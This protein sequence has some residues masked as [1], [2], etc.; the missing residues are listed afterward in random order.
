MLFVGIIP[1]TRRYFYQRICIS[2]LCGFTGLGQLPGLAR[3]LAVGLGRFRT[4]YQ[5]GFFRIGD[6]DMRW[7]LNSTWLW[8]LSRCLESPTSLLDYGSLLS[9]N[10]VLRDCRP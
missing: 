10:L 7:G 5:G 9:G 4:F 3:N 8:C 1:I 2:S 6:G